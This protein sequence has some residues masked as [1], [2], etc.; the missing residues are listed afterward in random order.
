[1]AP[2]QHV[3]ADVLV[4]GGGAAGARAALAASEAG[5]DVILVSKGPISR[6]GITITAGGGIQAPFHPDDSEQLFFDD[7]VE[8]GYRLGDRDLI[9]VLV[10]R[11][12][13]RILDLERYGVAFRKNPDGSRL[14]FQMP[15]QSAPRNVRLA[16]EGFGMMAALRNALLQSS[17]RVLE[18]IAV[19]DLTM[20][21]DR[22]VAGAVALDLKNGV[23]MQIH[24]AAVVIATGGC[25]ALWSV[26]DCPT[27]ATGD[28]LMIGFRAGSELIDLEMILFYPSVLVYPPAARGAFVHYEWLGDWACDGEIRDASGEP[29]LPKPLPVRDVAMRIMGEA[30]AD[31]RGTPHRG[32]WWDVT[33]SPKGYDAVDAFLQGQ[34]YRYLREKI[35]VDPSREKLEVAPGA[36][37]Q[38]GGIRIDRQGATGVVGLYAVPEAAGNYEGANRL[39][40]SALT[41]TQVFGEIA[42]SAAAAL[43][44]RAPRPEATETSVRAAFDRVARRVD[45]KATPVSLASA[46]QHLRESVSRHLGLHR[47]ADGLGTLQEE[48]DALRAE[49][50]SAC[51]R[52][53]GVYNQALLEILELENML[54]LAS[55]IG[56][57][58]QLREESRGHHF[59]TDFPSRDDSNWLRHTVLAGEGD[60]VC[61]ETV[62]VSQEGG[63]S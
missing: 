22:Q 28:G 58:A 56:R 14:Q 63:A 26:T 41:G 39:S 52:P 8:Y 2:D 45:R 23:L 62:P 46:R 34:H 12:C 25:E 18:D 60:D 11:A 50:A 61:H 19:I 35:G 6:S 3:T 48:I 59:R 16:Q 53:A 37:Y 57:A 49:L 36:H 43:A 55:L 9:E 4:I 24:S 31:G 15:G 32:L 29:V 5:S 42:G 17:V 10:S 13:D 44:A 51:V 33:Q 27:D 54:E 38:L 20:S 40:G 1:M 21:G 30:I 7:V 47:D